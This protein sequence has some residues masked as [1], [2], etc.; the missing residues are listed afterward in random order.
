LIGGETLVTDDAQRELGRFTLQDRLDTVFVDDRRVMHGVTP[1]Q[2]A[3]PRLP[4]CRDVL[5][6]TWKRG[7]PPGPPAG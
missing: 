1:V 2:P 6:I 5:V 3:D 4:S 7:G